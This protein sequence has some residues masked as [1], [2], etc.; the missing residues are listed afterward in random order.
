MED[1]IELYKS[2]IKH[3]EQYLKQ[4]KVIVS[5]YEFIEK[6]AEI[7]IYKLVIKDLKKWK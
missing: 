7:E 1:L 5:D 6:R 4:N 2:R 3:K